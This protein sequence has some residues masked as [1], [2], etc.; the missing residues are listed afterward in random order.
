[1][2]ASWDPVARVEGREEQG[3]TC[4]AAALGQTV[5]GPFWVSVSVS[6]HSSRSF[7]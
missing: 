3:G 7:Y 2:L 1:M 6:I 5:W 4:S